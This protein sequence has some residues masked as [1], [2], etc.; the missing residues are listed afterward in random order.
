[1]AI[2]VSVGIDNVFDVAYETLRAY[3][4]P[5]RIYRLSISLS[6]QPKKSQN[7]KQIQE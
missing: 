1:M 3:A 6:Y 2:D 7:L 4:M 5:G